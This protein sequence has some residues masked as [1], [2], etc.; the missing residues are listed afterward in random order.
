MVESP[1][2]TG[3]HD[4]LSGTPSNDAP[5]PPAV[6]DRKRFPSPAIFLAGATAMA[7]VL[8]YAHQAG[9][10]AAFRLPR[11]IIEVDLNAVLQ[12]LGF[13]SAGLVGFWFLADMALG[14]PRG[15]KLSFTA[16][17]FWFVGFPTL[18]SAGI[19]ALAY[20]TEWREAL[21]AVGPLI[22]VF[23]L[24]F[25]LPMLDWTAGRTIKERVE[26]WE[27]EL[28]QGD[29]VVG[30]FGRSF[31][32]ET[33]MVVIL[34]MFA[35]MTTFSASKG[36]EV[37]RKSFP[38]VRGDSAWVLVGEWGARAVLVE[39]DGSGHLT[40]AVRFLDRSA[41]SDL[42]LERLEV[43]PLKVEDLELTEIVAPAEPSPDSAA[44]PHDT[45]R[46]GL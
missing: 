10:A 8:A 25:V 11:T 19:I 20:R 9:R 45:S 12:S 27:G 13:V 6:L 16:I 24:L 15:A 22:A 21:W 1:E 43:G 38:V 36:V 42:I 3:E 26:V 14:K 30:I 40:A 7:Y 4:G 28:R 44:V 18:F 32:F 33:I 35:T 17:R 34:F 37:A 23:L 29:S 39:R 5:P 31:G 41:L 46:E 2:V